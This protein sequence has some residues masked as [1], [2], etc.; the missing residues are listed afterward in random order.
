MKVGESVVGVHPPTTAA[1]LTYDDGPTPGITDALLT[2]LDGAGGKATFFVMLSRVRRDSGLLRDILAAGH[3]I[4]LHGRDHRRLTQLP[5]DGLQDLV[6]DAR[7]RLED[8]AGVPVRWF[9]PPYGAQSRA[10]WRAAVD[11]GLTP[12]M[13][14]ISCRDWLTLPPDDYLADVRHNSLRGQIVLLHD[15]YAEADDGVDDGPPPEIDRVA[16]TRA[17]LAR[18]ADQGL[19]AVTLSAAVASAAPSWEVRLSGRTGLRSRL[20]GLLNA[21][22]VRRS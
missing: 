16:L 17:V 14:S 3:E 5:A 4:G 20:R 6:A 11:A 10:S 7:R 22:T 15:G 19:S 12:V 13:W 18:V 1:I 9:R 8:T 21:G 2:E